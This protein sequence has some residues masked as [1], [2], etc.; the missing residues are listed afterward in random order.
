MVASRALVGVAARSLAFV[1]AKV[2]LPQYRALV[3]LGAHGEQ[4]VSSLA[5]AL[6]IHPSTA[7]RLFDRLITKHLI[8]RTPSTENRREVTVALSPTGRALLRTVTDR[9]R[10]ELRRILTQL[11]TKDQRQLIAAFE[12]FACASREMPDNAWRLGWTS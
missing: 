12:R 2:T 5:D 1:D 7:T 11:S 6:E 3:L 10:R 8:E 9:R 4:N